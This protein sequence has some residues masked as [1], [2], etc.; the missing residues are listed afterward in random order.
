[1]WRRP[2]LFVIVLVFYTAFMMG[3]ATLTVWCIFDP[4]EG[5]QH[6]VHMLQT[7]SDWSFDDPPW[8]IFCGVPALLIVVTQVLFLWPLRGGIIRARPDGKPLMKTIIVAGFVAAVMTLA[9]L[10]GIAATVQ[11]IW[12]M[13]T[14]SDPADFDP[15]ET[16][17][18]IAI[19]IC[20]A[21]LVG[22][23]ILWTIVLKRFASRHPP[24]TQFSKIVGLLLA[25]TVIETVVLLPTDIMLRRRTDCYCGTGGF[26]ALCFS[27]WALL[28]LCGP[29]AYLAVTS[30]RRRAWAT[31]HCVRCGYAKGPSPAAKCP[32][33]GHDW[34]GTPAHE[35]SKHV[36][37][38]TDGT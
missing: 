37:R 17:M 24:D 21:A 31:G 38:A 25:G 34:S 27:A 32:E 22:S 18:W 4:I 2:W 10:L 1:M 16:G 14:A 15:G 28:W 3:L 6:A 33:C 30:K 20:G 12:A 26:Y 9:L 35:S 36:R 19:V 11:L 8:W 13:S 7:P 5:L 29:G 23:W